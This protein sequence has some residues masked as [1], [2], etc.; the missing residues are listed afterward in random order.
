M[1]HIRMSIVGIAT[2]CL[3]LL[4]LA[5]RA[6]AQCSLG[7]NYNGIALRAGSSFQAEKTTTFTHETQSQLTPPERPPELVARDGQ[8]RVR[9]EMT[10]GKFKVE[11]GEGAGTESVQHM[12]TICDPVSQK[13]VRLD[14]LNKTATIMTRGPLSQ[15]S[16]AQPQSAIQ[17]QRPYCKTFASAQS[18]GNIQRE[19]LGHQNIE[20]FDALGVRSTRP[21]H[22]LLNG[23]GTAPSFTTETWCSEELGVMLLQVHETAGPAE[24]K[25]ETRLTKIVPGEPDP[26]L[27]QIPPDYRIVERVPEERK[28]G[29]M[30]TPGI[31]STI[32][33]PAPEPVAA[34]PQ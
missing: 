4:S 7:S 16:A 27:F 28:P 25:T 6:A 30:G 29:Q 23:E 31:S 18:M 1:W 9:L 12:V 34:P 15:R 19:D 14:T 26:A 8:G 33:R 2:G 13:L 21:M 11:E 22:P 20:G 24:A 10:G 3:L 5:P 32:Q 17:M